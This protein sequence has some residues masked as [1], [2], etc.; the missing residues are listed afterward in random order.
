MKKFSVLLILLVVLCLLYL[1]A[2]FMGPSQI[3]VDRS[4]VISTPVNVVFREVSDF[5]N[6]GHW[7]PWHSSDPSQVRTYSEL[8][9]VEGAWMQWKGKKSSGRQQV[10]S[11]LPDRQLLS[12]LDLGRGELY[13][14]QLDFRSSATSSTISW[15]LS[16]ASI[17]FWRRPFYLFKK[18]SLES[19]MDEALNKLKVKCESLPPPAKPQVTQFNLEQPILLLSIRDSGNF[20]TVNERTRQ[21]YDEIVGFMQNKLSPATASRFAIYHSW[22][23]ELIDMELG[24]PIASEI[25]VE[26]RV[27]IQKIPAG[28][29]ALIEHKGPHNRLPESY[30]I[31]QKWMA[32]K[33]LEAIGPPV[34]E[35]V[36]GPAGTGDENE[37]LTRIYF[38]LPEVK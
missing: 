13:R 19:G 38:P 17:Q 34:E 26:G 14:S 30:T 15:N 31:I 2:A 6:W 16:T 1:G 7:S 3:S 21:V 25:P 28:T 4:I 22:S 10:V 37:W 8:M 35:Y 33:Q 12:R 32:E 36:L 24:I 5:H 23:R 29:Y 20:V 18:G 11:I 27:K 9:E